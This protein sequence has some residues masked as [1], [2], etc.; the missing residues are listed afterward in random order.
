VL[1]H[2][3]GLPKLANKLLT[4]SSL[5]D[6]LSEFR[7]QLA[8]KGLK[9]ATINRITNALKAALNLAA[10]NDERITRR[11][12]KTALKASGSEEAGVRHVIL[13]E[14][15][16]RTARGAAYRDSEEFG[17][18]YDVHDETGARS[19]QIV[20]LRGEDVQADFVNP[21][22]R[23]RQPRLLMPVSRKGSGK[24]VRAHIPVPIT[25]ELADRPR[26]RRAAEA[27]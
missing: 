17:L 18:L 7:E 24:K 15:D 22:T 1:S 25:P 3:A 21:Q 10:D 12:W 19:S 26:T 4:A 14:A 8:A 16:R 2:L 13:D 23:K 5:S 20:R 6:D 27:G 9:P 11:P